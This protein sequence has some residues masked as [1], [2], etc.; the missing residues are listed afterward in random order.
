MVLVQG[1]FAH[2]K[3]PTPLGPPKGPRRRAR[4]GSQGE[5]ISDE[6]GNLVLL[7]P[8]R[9]CTGLPWGK[10]FLNAGG[11][12]SFRSLQTRTKKASNFP[13]T[14]RLQKGRADLVEPKTIISGPE[15]VGEMASDAESYMKTL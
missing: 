5:A 12:F 4:L 7:T 6:R 3:T 8:H 2:K 1:Y 15:Y 14:P 9:E 13:R 11:H 10:L